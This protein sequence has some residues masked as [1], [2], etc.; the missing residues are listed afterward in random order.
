[1]FLY[2]PVWPRSLT[3]Q[4]YVTKALFATQLASLFCVYIVFVV[5]VAPRG[6][7]PEPGQRQRSRAGRLA[8]GR[9]Q[10]ARPAKLLP[11][12]QKALRGRPDGPEGQAVP[13]KAQPG[14]QRGESADALVA[15][16]ALH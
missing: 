10:E 3:P 11:E 8:D 5:C 2:S 13:F 12:C 6:Q 15:V 7:F 4:I 9:P 1:M 14:D 16:R